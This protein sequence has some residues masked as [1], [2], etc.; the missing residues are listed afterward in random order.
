MTD[1]KELDEAVDKVVGSIAMMTSK[2][3][4]RIMLMALFKLFGDT[5]ARVNDPELLTALHSDFS[6]IAV[7]LKQRASSTQL[8]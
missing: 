2:I 4:D 5:V 1:E 3:D 6:K 8:N 7:D